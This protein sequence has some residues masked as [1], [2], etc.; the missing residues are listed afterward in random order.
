MGYMLTWKRK[1]DTS[2]SETFDSEQDA[3]DAALGINGVAMVSQL[4][5][6]PF[7]VFRN[8]EE[9]VGDKAAAAMDELRQ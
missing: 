2:G 1:D 3:T 8:G 7:T 9:L 6:G 4:P 5:S